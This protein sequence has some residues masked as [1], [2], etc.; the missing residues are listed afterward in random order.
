[1]YKKILSVLCLMLM[2]TSISFGDTVYSIKALEND[3]IKNNEDLKVFDAK[4][5]KAEEDMRRSRATSNGT[6]N[7]LH[8]TD[9]DDDD[10]DYSMIEIDRR[11]LYQYPLENNKSLKDLENQRISQVNDLKLQAKK[12]FFNYKNQLAKYE[13]EKSKLELA[14]KNLEAAKS[15]L[16]LGLITELDYNNIKVELHNQELS[17]LDAQYQYEKTKRSINNYLDKDLESEIM[18]ME[19]AFPTEKYQIADVNKLVEDILKDN[20][21]IDSLQA[22]LDITK[23]NLWITRKYSGT[24]GKYQTRRDLENSIQKQIFDLDDKKAE[25]ELQIRSNYSDIL[26]ANDDIEISLSKR[27]IAETNYNIAKSQFE[28]GLISKLDYDSKENEFESS[29]VAYNE[30]L[31]AYYIKVEEFKT[32]IE[33]SKTTYE[34]D[35]K[36]R[37]I[38]D[39]GL[40]GY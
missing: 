23:T 12:D 25:I 2:L 35:D 3:Y 27:K 9:E 22:E 17:L 11:R 21:T 1:M 4:I 39:F 40:I 29:K 26:S 10:Y 30:A 15:K 38:E 28:N 14:N 18:L 6:Y 37:R 20:F 24:D 31:I 33:N 8:V 19:Y 5:K 7:K 16:D 13:L 32:F 34:D 36:I